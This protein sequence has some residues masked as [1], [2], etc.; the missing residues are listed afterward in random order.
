MGSP[1][2][3]VVS[4]HALMRVSRRRV[5]SRALDA[6]KFNIAL[7]RAGIHCQSESWAGKV[8]HKRMQYLSKSLVFI[9]PMALVASAAIADPQADIQ[10]AIVQGQQRADELKLRL[11]QSQPPLGAGDVRQRM[12][13]DTLHLQ[14][15]QRQQDLN[16][17]QFRQFDTLRQ[18]PPADPGAA[19]LQTLEQQQMFERDRQLQLQQFRLEEQ[20]ARER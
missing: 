1:G 19:R 12:E 17:Q 6:V 11:Q 5:E 3:A 15:L 2:G 8:L 14:Q 16:T 13:L 20:R 10:R 7:R 4:S 9:F 18:P